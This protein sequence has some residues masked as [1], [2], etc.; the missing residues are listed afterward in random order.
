MPCA[1]KDWQTHP[2]RARAYGDL[3]RELAVL[4]EH[5][6][7]GYTEAKTG[8]IRAG[9]QAAREAFGDRY[10]VPASAPPAAS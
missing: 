4:Y 9:T 8:F 1:G 10:G 2:E 7:D 3:K 6:R 5:D